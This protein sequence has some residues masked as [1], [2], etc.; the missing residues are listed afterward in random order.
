M[1]LGVVALYLLV[2]VEVTSLLRNRLPRRLWR[3]VHSTSFALFLLGTGH[4]L[5]AGSE[6][7]NGAVRVS[8]AAMLVAFM[9]LV[10]YRSLVRDRGG[11]AA[12]GALS[13]T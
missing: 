1:A 7:G 4:A 6:A 9:F 2:A 13:R 11:A 12:G 3:A 5:A 10:V 8:A